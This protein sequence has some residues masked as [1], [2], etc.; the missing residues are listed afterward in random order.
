[1]SRYCEAPIMPFMGGPPP[2]P[3]AVSAAGR[4]INKVPVS[5][6]ASS[7]PSYGGWERSAWH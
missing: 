7:K 3:A 5:R 4:S 1:M 6:F 2:G